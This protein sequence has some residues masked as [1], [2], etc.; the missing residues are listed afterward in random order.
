MGIEIRL[1]HEIV[2]DIDEFLTPPKKKRQIIIRTR[3]YPLIYYPDLNIEVCHI[4][5]PIVQ[6][7]CLYGTYVHTLKQELYKFW[8]L[9][10]MKWYVW[11]N[12]SKSLKQCRLYL[13]FSP[14]N[15][16]SVR[17]DEYLRNC[18]SWSLIDKWSSKT[19]ISKLKWKNRKIVMYFIFINDELPRIHFKCENQISNA[20][21]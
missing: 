14:I 4:M 1:L 9:R 12:F 18:Q 17:E 7:S 11:S 3:T 16:F 6:C 13:N 10:W 21:E 20:Y 8:Y 5:N 19:N 15:I 2:F